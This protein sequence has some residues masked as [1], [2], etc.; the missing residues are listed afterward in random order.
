MSIFILTFRTKV[1]LPSLF[2]LM[3]YL[4]QTNLS[5]ILDTVANSDLL[6]K[7]KTLLKLD[8][9]DQTNL[10]VALLLSLVGLIGLWDV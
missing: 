9:N 5:W 10:C 7:S 8:L 1:I 2:E 3:D 6:G 4:Y